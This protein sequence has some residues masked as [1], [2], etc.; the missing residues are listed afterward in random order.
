MKFTK[1][2][3]WTLATKMR[4]PFSKSGRTTLGMGMSRGRSYEPEM[5]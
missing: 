3:W 2:W 5:K 4:V 1:W